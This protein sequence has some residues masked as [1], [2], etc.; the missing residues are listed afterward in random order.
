MEVTEYTRTYPWMS[1]EWDW[2][3]IE[4]SSCKQRWSLRT[5]TRMY[6]AEFYLL[7]TMMASRKFSMYNYTGNMSIWFWSASV[8][9]KNYQRSW[10]KNHTELG[11]CGDRYAVNVIT[12]LSSCINQLK[13]EVLTVHIDQFVKC[14]QRKFVALKNKQTNKP[15]PN[16]TF[17]KSLKIEI[18]PTVF[19]GGVI[20]VN[21]LTL[22]KLYG[23]RRLS[24]GANIS[25]LYTTSLKNLKTFPVKISRS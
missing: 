24:C 22:H 18:P 14:C 10:F 7:K 1:I 21:K 2:G 15:L 23:K 13:I 25:R 8:N 17:D 16:V 11:G 12:Y 5:N 4:Y 20:G 6:K 9:I 3:K 19:N